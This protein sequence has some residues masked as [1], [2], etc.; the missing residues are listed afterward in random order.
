MHA[1]TTTVRFQPGTADEAARIIREIMLPSAGAQHGFK[2]AWMLKS[3]TDT[4]KCIIISLWD[5]LDDLLA[6]AP[7]EEIIPLLEPLDDF[8]SESSQD[9][10]EVLFQVDEHAYKKPKQ[11]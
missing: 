11:K 7:P 3:D 10:C 4:E 8:I 6:S 5:T 9:T 2:G 1:R